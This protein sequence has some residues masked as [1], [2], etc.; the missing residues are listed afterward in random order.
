M[1]GRVST[2]VINL[3]SNAFGYQIFQKVWG[4]KPSSLII[5]IPD[6]LSTCTKL[7]KVQNLDFQREFSKSKIFWIFLIFFIEE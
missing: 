2:R 4:N 1:A 3:R 5:G 7:C 6:A